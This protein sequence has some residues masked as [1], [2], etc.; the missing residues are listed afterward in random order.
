VDFVIVL[1]LK[2]LLTDIDIDRRRWRQRDST[3]LSHDQHTALYTNVLFA[4]L[5]V[6]NSDGVRN[7]CYAVRVLNENL[8]ATVRCPSVLLSVCLNEP[9]FSF[10]YCGCD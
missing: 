6:G 4:F 7:L 9:R 5:H 2:I 8:I 1:L 3:V 10:Y